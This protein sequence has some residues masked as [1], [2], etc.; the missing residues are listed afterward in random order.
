VIQKLGSMALLVAVFVPWLAAAQTLQIRVVASNGVRAALED[1]RQECERAMGG[2]LAIEFGTTSALRQRI[3]AGEAFDVAILTSAV[4]EELSKRGS[5]VAD[6]G[7]E[8]ARSG[9]GVGIRRGASRPE[10][11]TSDELKGVLLAA[12]SVT[13]AADGASRVH[14][15]AMLERLGIADEV[16]QKATLELGSARAMARVAEGPAELV[17]TLISEIL[18]APGIELLGPLP[19]ELQREI[20]FKAGVG[21]RSGNQEASKALIRCLGAPAAARTFLARGMEPRSAD[22]FVEVNGLRIHYLDWG[23]SGKQPLILLHGIGRVAH[24]FDHVVEHFNESYHV[25]AVDL[26]GHGESAWDPERAYLVEDYV[27]D[28]AGFVG[29]LGLRDIVIWGNSTG[30]RVAQVFAGMQ[31]DRVAAVIV[32]DVGPE[33]PREIASRVTSRIQKEDE[34]GWSSE[35]ELLAEL[36]TGN[37]RTAEEVLRALAHYGSKPRPD[38]RV[39]WRRD[40]GIAKGFVPTEL[41]KQVAQIQSPILYIV[42]GRSAIVPPEIQEKLK[43][44]LPQARIVTMPDA[45]H[46][47]SE[48]RPKEYL[49]I[50]DRFL[51]EAR[52]KR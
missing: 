41:W 36:K 34:T 22:R 2:A 15:E 43:R 51:I 37:P 20:G 10:I 31:P 12:K 27:K 25:I 26:R 4:V 3:E 30:G 17:L 23:S 8:L 32:E 7:F 28:I 38:G 40:P 24:T 6:S 49:E 47:P 42:G 13:Y 14:I 46:Y 29:A 16:G 33:R 48:E 50:V 1:V 11:R 19:A 21:A 45:G 44:T 52:A 9:I 35:A 39:I 18:P 5:V